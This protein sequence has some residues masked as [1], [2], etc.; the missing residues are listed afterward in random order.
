MEGLFGIGLLILIYFVIFEFIP[1]KTKFMNFE[2]ESDYGKKI[3]KEDN[4]VIYSIIVFII[5]F[6]CLAMFVAGL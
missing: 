1:S 4:W 2:D 3:K 5:F 6:I